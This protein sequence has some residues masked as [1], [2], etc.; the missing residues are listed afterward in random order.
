MA[1]PLDLTGFEKPARY[2]GNL[3]QPALYQKYRSM[4]GDKRSPGSENRVEQAIE[5]LQFD[6][7]NGLISDEQA[8]GVLTDPY[9]FAKEY[10]AAVADVKSWESTRLDMQTKEGPS[11]FTLM[12]AWGR[13][14]VATTAFDLYSRTPELTELTTGDPR[15]LS[16][17]VPAPPY[18]GAGSMPSKPVARQMGEIMRRTPSGS[19][20]FD[21]FLVHGGMTGGLAAPGVFDELGFDRLKAQDAADAMDAFLKA[22][23]QSKAKASEIASDVAKIKSLREPT[24]LETQ[25]EDPSLISNIITDAGGPLLKTGDTDRGKW[26]DQQN[27]LIKNF[28]QKNLNDKTRN[29]SNAIQS[30]DDQQ[31]DN[32]NKEVEQANDQLKNITITHSATKGGDKQQQVAAVFKSKQDAGALDYNAWN[33]EKYGTNVTPLGPEA[34]A[35]YNEWYDYI[36][37]F[38][39]KTPPKTPPK[40]PGSP[41]AKSPEKP[42][43]STSD[44]ESPKT[45]TDPG[46]G[47]SFDMTGNVI[48]SDIPMW[49]ATTTPF[50]AYSR[51]RLAAYP[52]APIGVVGS[53]AGQR[54]MASGYQPEYGRFKLGAAMGGFGGDLGSFPASSDEQAMGEAFGRY[55]ARPRTRTL[56][57][58]RTGYGQFS[59]YLGQLAGSG[60]APEDLPLNWSTIF[61]RG[62][63]GLQPSRSDVLSA[64]MAALGAKPGFGSTIYSNLGTIYDLMEQQ[65]GP[66]AGAKRFADYVG[67]GFNS[68]V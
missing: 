21:P 60:T 16:Y 57:D 34:Q 28:L 56:G 18:S 29:L 27:A 43:A 23:E 49:Q 4:I 33:L 54:A 5:Q 68:F 42:S 15:D 65:Y 66:T 47:A 8:I 25:M 59:D 6:W 51:Y 19:V 2:E 24:A 44:G 20:Q 7:V 62:E 22:Q 38:G 31:I 12:D 3:S 53:A 10:R 63:E 61:G 9:A 58:Y 41:P 37:N 64:S 39:T 17:V 11:E 67:T 26:T 45:F 50:G 55:L 46:T 48:D 1:T 40:K 32:A 14:R 13:P 36:L 52:D 30:G 35:R